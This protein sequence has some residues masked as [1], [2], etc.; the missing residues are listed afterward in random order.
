[1]ASEEIQPMTLQVTLPSVIRICTP[2]VITFFSIR[3]LTYDERVHLMSILSV[4]LACIRKE[5]GDLFQKIL[6]ALPDP[7]TNQ[8]LRV[9]FFPDDGVTHC[10][11][12]AAST[13]STVSLA[14][15]TNEIEF[16]VA[17]IPAIRQYCRRCWGE[18]HSDSKFWENAYLWGRDPLHARP[19]GLSLSPAG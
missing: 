16:E 8:E 5:S 17:S 3:P 12:K 19:A 9:Y 2:A 10:S 11:L 4:D 6:P 15:E 1:M 13:S 7:E 18:W 14:G